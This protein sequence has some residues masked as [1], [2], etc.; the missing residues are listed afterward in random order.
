MTDYKEL[1]ERL[2]DTGVE[3][4]HGYAAFKVG[5]LLGEAA[6]AL[7]ALEAHKAAAPL[8]EKHAPNGGARSGCLV[9][10]GMRLSG[11]L[12]EIDYVCGEPN[13]YESSLYDA[14]FDEARVVG[15]VKALRAKL[16]EA[17]LRAAM[18]G[19]VNSKGDDK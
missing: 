3:D 15:R 7:E 18:V 5:R 8:C 2:M 19:C 17:L 4:L 16:A 13:E 12:S 11:A 14:D 9:C 1:C 10:S 6:E